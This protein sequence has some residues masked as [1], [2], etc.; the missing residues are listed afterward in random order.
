MMKKGV[1]KIAV[2][3]GWIRPIKPN[4]YESNTG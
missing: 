3:Q 2:Q 4:K 1:L